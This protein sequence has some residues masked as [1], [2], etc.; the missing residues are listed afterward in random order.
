MADVSPTPTIPSPKTPRRTHGM[1]TRASV[2]EEKYNIASAGTKSIDDD[3]ERRGL[4]KV[5][6]SIPEG[7]GVVLGKTKILNCKKNKGACLNELLEYLTD[8]KK[9]DSECNLIYMSWHGQPQPPINPLNPSEEKNVFFEVPNNV[10]FI[11]FN[12]AKTSAISTSEMEKDIRQGLQYGL[13]FDIEYESAPLDSLVKN[14]KVYL[15]GDMM[16]S[17]FAIQEFTNSKYMDTYI[18]SGAARYGELFEPVEIG[19][20]TVVSRFKW[21]AAYNWAQE[22]KDEAMELLNEAGMYGRQDGQNI[23]LNQIGNYFNQNYKNKLNIIVLF[24]CDPPIKELDDWNEVV[25]PKIIMKVIREKDYLDKNGREQFKSLWELGKKQK[26]KGFKYSGPENIFNLPGL[27]KLD[28]DTGK[29]SKL[30]PIQRK[31][32]MHA[33][34]KKNMKTFEAA[35]KYRRNKYKRNLKKRRKLSRKHINP[36]KRGKS[37]RRKPS[38]KPSRKPRRKSSRKPRRKPSRKSSRKH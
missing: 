5:K 7:K 14:G 9:R 28:D 23:S 30:T 27:F 11:L 4:F 8:E 31:K 26:K 33:N 13:L 22:E 35:L 32:L 2:V 6:P 24:N 16:H 29:P 20:H 38:R 1:G 34:E 3:K 18:L 12:K 19:E 21:E 10:A 15:P 25:D 37:I 36:R 17:Y